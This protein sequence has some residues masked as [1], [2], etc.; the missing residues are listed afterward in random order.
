VGYITAQTTL[1]NFS[2]AE[3]LILMRVRH[4]KMDLLIV[5]LN[6]VIPR[7]N[8]PYKNGI[9]VLPFLRM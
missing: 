5:T 2:S 7:F 9:L 8:V 6:L 4:K 1:S 3:A